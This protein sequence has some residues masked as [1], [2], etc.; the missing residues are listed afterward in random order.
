MEHLQT[1][2]KYL[3]MKKEPTTTSW[4][5]YQDNNWNISLY[6]FDRAEATYPYEYMYT[7]RQ[8]NTEKSITVP[9]S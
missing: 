6:G 5:V 9:I 3:H 1:I 7:Y 8:A 2:D 4:C